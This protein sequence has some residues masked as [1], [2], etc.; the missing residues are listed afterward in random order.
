MVDSELRM[1]S[2]SFRTVRPV[3]GWVSLLVVA[4]LGTGLSGC[5]IIKVLGYHL[6][7]QTEPMPAE[8]D[9]LPG[10]TVLV[11]VWVPPEVMWDYP[12]IRL[13]LSAGICAH[14]KDNVKKIKL[15]DALRVESELEKR[16]RADRDPIEL[17]K[18]FRADMVVHVSLFAFSIRDPGM[19][20]FYRGRM[21]ASVAVHDLT[22]TGG[23]PERF[24][25]KDVSVVVPEKGPVGFANTTPDKVRQATY[26]EFIAEV[27]RKFHDW[28]RPLE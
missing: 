10:K 8:F 2:A 19:A 12:K 26:Q 18:E 25:L 20:H 15:V 9:K 22:R 1:S 24:G 21:S 23:A 14:L 11:Y 7:P 6:S 3:F 4:L 16:G 13:D 5:N 27:G 17:G 28:E